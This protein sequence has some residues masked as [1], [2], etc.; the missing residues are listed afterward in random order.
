MA[1]M[2]LICWSLSRGGT[3]LMNR[4]ISVS[5]LVAGSNQHGNFVGKFEMLS[6]LLRL[7]LLKLWLVS[8]NKRAISSLV[9]YGTTNED[10]ILKSISFS[11]PEE[12]DLTVCLHQPKSSVKWFVVLFSFCWS[13]FTIQLNY[14]THDSMYDTFCLYPSLDNNYKIG[15][16]CRRDTGESSHLDEN[17]CIKSTSLHKKKDKLKLRSSWSDVLGQVIL[18]SL[19]NFREDSLWNGSS[20]I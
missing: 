13:Q 20:A 14:S 9:W 19:H 17:L 3:A 18:C 2:G 16:L 1:L 10:R 7:S 5:S 15:W 8:N 12:M 6:I 4:L 11:S